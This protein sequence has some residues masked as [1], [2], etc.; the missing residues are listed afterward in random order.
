MAAIRRGRRGGRTLP[1]SLDRRLATY[2]LSGLLTLVTAAGASPT[3]RHR[4]P[5]VGH[6]T[7]R[8]LALPIHGSKAVTP[9]LLE[10][11]V[12][13]VRRDE[14]GIVHLEDFLPNDPRTTV[15]ARRRDRLVRLFPGSVERPVADVE[16][17]DLVA[18]AIDEF[19]IPRRGFGVRDYVD[20]GLLYLDHAIDVLGPA[21]LDSDVTDLD[22]AP[23]I[24]GAEYAAAATLIL[25]PPPTGIIGSAG[26]AAALRFA[27]SPAATLPYVPDHP[28]SVFG[29]YLA[30]SLPSADWPQLPRT[31]GRERLWWLPSAFIPDALGYGV[32]ALARDAA[33]DV[34]CA[35]RFAQL[36]A[37]RARRALW[38]F[39]DLLGP[40]D[41]ETGPMVS[42]GD[43]IQW[44][45]TL[46]EARALLV[47]MGARLSSD[48]LPFDEE[49]VAVR[50]SREARDSEEPIQVPMPAGV[51]TLDPRTEVVPLL[52]VA[53]AGHVAA[54]Q[55]PGAAVMSLDDLLWTARTA[56]ADSD[57]FM[58]CR[59]LAAPDRPPIFGWE[60]INLWEWWRNNGKTFFGGGAA[61]SFMSIDPHWGNA[62]WRRA[63]GQVHLERALLATGLPPVSGFDV[64]ERTGSGP[65]ELYA[66]GEPW[67]TTT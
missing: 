45:S 31:S 18:A 34:D 20:A 27:T 9:A 55:G 32:S 65:P 22:A 64:I 11:L 46:G 58:F 38:R 25:H 61:P 44:V 28:Q 30:V 37:D 5:S 59:E 53:T 4:W 62:E 39:G 67:D 15:L 29:R 52:V 7:A 47:Q 35:R 24:S 12:T 41:H 40:A 42:P 60:A 2:S 50:I 1:R 3:V 54:P 14:P 36:A 23:F 26:R 17:A 13:V 57:L 19:L 16:R 10:Q 56:D 48:R 63:S 21:W 51:L 43:V 33:G 6:L 8:S 66:W 49:P